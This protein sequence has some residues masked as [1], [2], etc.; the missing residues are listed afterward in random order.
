M[1]LDGSVSPDYVQV[2]EFVKPV[3]VLPCPLWP[4]TS[5]RLTD[6][7]RFPCAN[8]DSGAGLRADFSATSYGTAFSVDL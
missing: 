8:P 5:A 7:S 1:G 2:S 4:A 6:F 3:L